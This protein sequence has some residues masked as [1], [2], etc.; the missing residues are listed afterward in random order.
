MRITI[1]GGGNIGTQFAVHCAEKKHDVIIFTS[2]PGVFEKHLQIVDEKQTVTHEGDIRLATNK[3]EEAF[4][5]CDLV[6]VTYPA[7]MMKKAA[8]AMEPYISSETLIGAVPGNGGS[9]CAFHRLIERGN[10]FFLIERVPAIARLVKKG[11]TVKSTGY[12]KEMHVAALPAAEAE[13]CAKLVESF[14]DIQCTS[15]PNILNLTMTPSNP[16]L[17]TTRLRTM[18]SDYLPG[19]FYDRIPLFYEEWTDQ[20]S[21]FLLKCDDEVQAICRALPEHHLSY[22]KSLRDHYESYTVGQ[23]TAKISGIPAFKGIATP[24]LKVGNKYIPDLHSRYFTADFSYGL[25]IIKQVASFAGVETPY[26]DDVM[27]WYEGIALENDSFSYADYGITSKE[28]FD[29]FYLH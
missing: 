2:A 14:F 17:H 13:K 22:V 19:V 20:A 27:R 6:I 8:E 11:S 1:V 18:F 29:R 15:I 5:D 28:A 25:S 4:S 7:N 23:M 3:P 10:I 9:E 21:E 16:I 26:I 12:R 24:S